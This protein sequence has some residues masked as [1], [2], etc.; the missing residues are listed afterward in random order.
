MVIAH[1]PFLDA[2]IF[3]K[4]A[5]SLVKKGHRVT[6]IVPRNNGKLLDIDG[7]PFNN[8]FREKVFTHEGIR[9]VTYNSEIAMQGLN[10][11]LADEAVWNREGFNNQLTQLA[12]QEDADIYHT[13][14]FLSLFA[15]IGVKRLMKSRRGKNIKLIYDSHELTPDPLDPRYTIER[16]DLLKEKLLTM[17]NEV[18]YI[19]TVS[20][21]IKSWYLSHKPE[22]PVEVIYNSPPLAKN[23]VPK[24]N[25]KEGLT[26]GYVGNFYDNKGSGEKLIDIAESCSKQMDFQCKIIGGSR[27]GSSLKIP[28]HLESNIKSTGWV[29]FGTIP[30]HLKEVDIGWIDL[31]NV[32]QSL[33][34]NY[35]MPNKFFSYLNNGIPV[36]VNK[37]QEMAE[38]IR[39]YKC[40]YVIDKYN[41]TSQDYKDAL[42]YLNE[43]KKELKEMSQNGR[44]VMENLYSWEKMEVR[45]INVYNKLQGI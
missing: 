5:K 33:N 2:R 15:G 43:N 45:L 20:D 41:A 21:A 44:K 6:M 14:E 12:I 22:L 35:A 37:C 30:E 9:I 16:R 34:N 29:E 39:R 7:T 11:V 1:H 28:K 3:K 4:E 25:D 40:G 38:F 26:I 17:L 31:E 10:K 32:D 8:R 18:D 19:I 36:L 42:V 13:H 23:Y 27:F 24:D